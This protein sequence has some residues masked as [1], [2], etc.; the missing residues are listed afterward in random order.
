MGLRIIKSLQLLQ[1]VYS[2]S[3][4]E[5][6][7]RETFLKVFQ[8]LGVP[9]AILLKEGAKP[10][11]LCA[12]RNIPFALRDK[13]R[14]ELHR[15]E[16]MGVI[17]KVTEPSEWC[18]GI[19]VVP[20]STGAVRICVDLKPLNTSVLRE[21]HDHSIPT[22]DETLAQLS[23]VTIFSKIDANLGFWQ[24]LLTKESQAY[25]TFTSAFG[26]YCFWKLPFGI[27]SAPELFQRRISC[28][29]DGLKRVLCHMDDVLIH[30]TTQQEHNQRLSATLQQFESAGVTL[31]LSKCEFGVDRV[32]FLGHIIDKEGVRA[33]PDKVS[34]VVNM[35]APS[36]VPELR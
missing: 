31:N 26:R 16:S 30:G 29:L 3:L 33:D 35:K 23:G 27:S 10:Y 15:M 22:V 2:A 13:V 21:P 18:A 14:K 20:K 34:A 36:N 1:Q 11:A 19:V 7:I 8:G 17:K 6:T 32:K 9:Y 28:V 12:P 24:T 25:N 4:L 5:R